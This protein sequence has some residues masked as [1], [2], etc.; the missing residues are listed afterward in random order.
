MVLKLGTKN[1]P[2]AKHDIAAAIGH[3][4]ADGQLQQC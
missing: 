4:E 3:E 2:N 1:A